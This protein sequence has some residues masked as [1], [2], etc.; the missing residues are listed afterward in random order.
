MSFVGS[1]FYGVDTA[2]SWLL[3]MGRQKQPSRA[4]IHP[5]FWPRWMPT[6]TLNKP[7]AE[8]FGV[9]G[10]PI[11]MI[12]RNKGKVI[13]DYKG[14]RD[15]AGLVDYLKKISGLAQLLTSAEQIEEFLKEDWL[16]IFV[17]GVFD[18]LEGEEYKLEGEEHFDWC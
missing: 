6:K 15:E 12:I 1:L 8:E 5:S 7:L 13:S 11:V 17:I 9:K 14:S 4:M 3:S 18:K 10:F 16:E 2:K